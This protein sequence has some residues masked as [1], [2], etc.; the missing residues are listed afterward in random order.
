MALALAVLLFGLRPTMGGSTSEPP[1]RQSVL[2]I[3]EGYVDTGAVLIYCKSFGSGP[4]LLILHGGPGAS[5][6]YFLPHL[7]PLAR[8]NRLVFIDE[9]GSGK[10]TKL[11]DPAAYSV[12]NMV[13]DAE[14]VRQ[15]VRPGKINLLGHSCGGVLA[16]AYAL[17]YQ[18]H[19]KHLVLC[20]TFHSTKAMNEIFET[21]KTGM[22]PELRQRIDKLEAAGL[23]GCGK[24]YEKNR[25]P[26][27]YMVAAWGEGYFP[28]LF[29]GRPDANFDPSAAG[30][31]A[32]DV[33][34]EMWGSHGE[35][36][37]DGNLASVEYAE[38]LPSIKVPTLITVG[39]HDRVCSFPFPRNE[40]VNTGIKAGGITGERAHDFRGSA[41][42]VPGG[43]AGFSVGRTVSNT[44][45]SNWRT[46]M[47][48]TK[49]MDSRPPAMKRPVSCPRPRCGS[50]VSPNWSGVGP[51]LSLLCWFIL[52]GI[53]TPVGAQAPITGPLAASKNPNHFQDARGNPVILCGSQTWNT[54]QDWG[55]GGT[56][57]PPDFDA[58]VGFL[59]AHGH[60]FTLL[61]R[62]ELPK[63]SHLPV[64][65]TNPPDFTVSPHP[66]LRTG[67]G[68]A[69][70][71]GLKFDLTKFDPDYFGRL[72][73]RVAALN[74]AGIYAGIYLFTGEFL[75]RFRSSTD[76]YPFSGPNNVNGV[77]DGYRGGTAETGL[78]SVTMTAT[79]AIT[80]LQ[81]AY[82][83]KTIETLNDLPNV[84]WIVSE[85]APIKSTWW[86]SHLIALVRACERTQRH[87]HP[88]G[89]ATLE[90]PSDAILYNSDA[91]WVAPWVWVSPTN[92]C[93]SGQPSCKVNINDSDHSYFGMWNDTPQ[94]NRNLCP[95][96]RNGIGAKPDPR[97]DNFRDNLGYLLRYS[98]RLNL[99]QVVPRSSLCSIKYC[100][101]QTPAVGAEYLV[102][103][104]D[105]GAFALDVS[106][107]PS[108]RKLAVEWFNPA[109][110]E[111]ITEHPIPAGSSARAFRP[112]FS[113]DAVLYLVDTEGHR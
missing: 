101:A 90:S 91:D 48:L 55:T 60:N 29:Q 65:A 107:M 47:N 51:V 36:V 59:K 87:Q 10:S 68:L 80:E 83:R 78:A 94:K 102:Y 84:L 111:T 5:H 25:Y 26:S 50:M 74:R 76:G 45:M 18:I 69:T 57:Q 61:W 82:V 70:D 21:M 66:W 23:F 9:R 106:A 15:S 105:G 54:L 24:G 6:D 28:Y 4:P 37:I 75:L 22:S 63:F 81:D 86:N 8:R 13:E 41:S 53:E 72:R 31:M 109:T 40:S 67:P 95:S 64:T 14:F 19:L 96:P 103:A 11:E 98:R 30:N 108:T 1:S 97:W 44:S 56:V 35:F 16:Q 100:L 34:R 77:D 85:E 92:S 3:E 49:P 104:P 58:F 12:E 52:L 7:A 39:D 62:S 88:I 113:G 43:G 112:P 42:T 20:S 46:G 99:A 32:W 79:N 33:Y 27:E 71:G 73:A 17:K 93:G 38:R 89:Y 110:G 2:K